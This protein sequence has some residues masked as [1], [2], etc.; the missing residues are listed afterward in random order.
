MDIIAIDQFSLSLKLS[1]IL[2]IQSL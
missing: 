1:E 2:V